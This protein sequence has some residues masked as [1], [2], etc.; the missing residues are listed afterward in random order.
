MDPNKSSEISGQQVNKTKF[1]K[2]YLILI[3]FI[4][5]LLIIVGLGSYRLGAER[6]ACVSDRFQPHDEILLNASPS[7]SPLNLLTINSSNYS[8]DNY[9]TFQIEYPSSYLATTDDML[10]SYRSQGGM[11]PPRIILMKKYQVSADK[12]YFNDIT[13]NSENECIA[14]W[15]TL[16]FDSIDKWN[17]NVPSFVGTLSNKETISVGNKSADL[18]L[19]SKSTGNVYV[20]YLQANKINNRSYYFNTCNANNKNDFVNVIKSIK[21]RGDP[22]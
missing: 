21:F 18:Y 13:N 8:D 3:A 19:L 11:A 20:A 17:Q 15:S 10:T 1:S 22:L 4:T 7:P 14:I 9:G 2:K 12:N 6:N 5:L 16:G